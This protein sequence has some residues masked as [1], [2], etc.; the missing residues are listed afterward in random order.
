[1]EKR[2][3]NI[4]SDEYY[5]FREN[6]NSSSDNKMTCYECYLIDE[7]WLNEFEYIL[8]ENKKNK[9]A[10]MSIIPF[11]KNN[12]QILDTFPKAINFLENNKNIYFIN[13]SVID[14]MYSNNS[15]IDL[16]NKNTVQIY[17][18]NNIVIIEFKNNE[19]NKNIIK[20]LLLVNALTK[21]QTNIF[22]ISVKMFGKINIFKKI[23]KDFN[24]NDGI[25]KN[26]I[27]KDCIIPL[28]K[29]L[30]DIINE[31]N[32]IKTHIK[33]DLLTFF[34]Y[35]FYYEK[36]FKD[37][38]YNYK[39]V[40]SD[41]Q[42]Y[43]LINY[44]W[45]NQVKKY[46]N[47]DDLYNLLKK[48]DEE[49]KGGFI[50]SNL[51]QKINELLKIYSN[52]DNFSFKPLDIPQHLMN[53]DKIVPP[54][55]W[56]KDT[57]IYQNCFIV[58]SEIMKIINKYIIFNKEINFQT[59]KLCVNFRELFLFDENNFVMFGNLN[60]LIFVIKYVILFKSSEIFNSEKKL[61]LS[62]NSFNKYLIKRK[63]E[64]DSLNKQQLYNEQNQIIGQLI[65][66]GNREVPKNK[67]KEDDFNI[68]QFNFYNINEGISVGEI[69][70]FN[71][72]FNG[73]TSL[74]GEDNK[75]SLLNKKNNEKPSEKNESKKEENNL[76]I[77]YQKQNSLLNIYNTNNSHTK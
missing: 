8:K 3:L 49:N 18:R 1:M 66:I 72:N 55:K 29:Y 38:I 35:I 70:S 10:L 12:P 24:I 27:D 5:S 16:K 69:K 11:P 45:L 46:Y 51:R 47:Y 40:F 60:E 36:S 30:N 33:N 63:A 19:N 68:N 61:L 25:D 57:Q 58:N 77:L 56:E 75:D 73:G 6:I 59:K 64:I 23:L 14:L 34:I 31:K 62:L 17:P 52:E 53:I 74:K 48:K 76:I 65:F 9:N 37:N 2:I 43:Y 54:K 42:N 50:F 28:R 4:I 22:I 13:A 71:F 44:E 7:N 67:I 21:D 15:N 39:N 26:S 32:I 41:F 20:S